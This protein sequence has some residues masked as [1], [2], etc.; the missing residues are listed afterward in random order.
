MTLPQATGG[1]GTL[2]Y[3]LMPLPLPAGLSF[4][5]TTRTLSGTP[6]TVATTI[7]TYTVADEATDT[8]GVTPAPQMASLNF[9]LMVVREFPATAGSETEIT[10]PDDESIGYVTLPVAA[11]LRVS[12]AFEAA[13]DNPPAGSEFSLTVDIA[14]ATP[15]VGEATVC[16]PT[17]GVPAGREAV[18]Y[19]YVASDSPPWT[20]ISSGSTSTREGGFVCGEITA[21]SPFAVGYDTASACRD[22]YL[23]PCSPLNLHGRSGGCA[24]PTARYRPRGRRHADLHL[25]PDAD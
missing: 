22:F 21:F 15:L 18:L 8:D 20:D 4:D 6:T 7:L 2:T 1:I 5:A 11:A 13:A 25:H 17:S 3:T 16:L 24:D 9:T 12:E 19:H 10:L 23:H 14:Q